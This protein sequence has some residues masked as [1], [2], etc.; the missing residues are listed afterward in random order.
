[1]ALD[2][3][4][5]ERITEAFNAITEEVAGLVLEA[6]KHER[7]ECA[8]IALAIDSCR[9]NEKEIARAILARSDS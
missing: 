8:N 7:Q 9:G 1:M 2:T 4:H 5:G 3:T 6:L